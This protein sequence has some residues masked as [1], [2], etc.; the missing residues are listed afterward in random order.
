V[1]Q[2]EHCERCKGGV[3]GVTSPGVTDQKLPRTDRQSIT[4]EG[5][6]LLCVSDTTLCVTERD[7]Q[8]V[9]E[10]LGSEEQY[11]QGTQLEC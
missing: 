1:D 9:Q 10:T 2:E 5:C 4:T 6:G 3:P 8:E 7:N 11:K